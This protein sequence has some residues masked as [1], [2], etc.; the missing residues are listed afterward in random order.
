MVTRWLRDVKA[1]RRSK[2]TIYGMR[3]EQFVRVAS[4]VIAG[5]M[6]GPA[7][8][9]AASPPPF[10][11]KDAIARFFSAPELRPAWFS[12]TLL[13]AV[14]FERLRGV[15]A[16][17]TSV[18]G[19]YRAIDPNGDEYTVLFDRGTAQASGSLDAT[20]A[21]LSLR[22]HGFQSAA[23]QARLQAL[24]T[25]TPVP[26][27]WFA[28]SF[29]AQFPIDKVQPVITGITTQLGK[30]TAVVPRPDGSYDGLF[31]NGSVNGEIGLDAAGKIVFLFFKSPQ[32]AA[33]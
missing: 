23:N 8:A 19:P 12:S 15:P 2:R 13:A 10:T 6:F 16:S 24:L 4:G 5:G 27:D 9:S 7:G 21:F 31:A 33:H 26:A 29:L 32:T 22:F 14:P 30:F 17:I 25:T 11:V 1:P 18:L 3:R 28:P 20:G